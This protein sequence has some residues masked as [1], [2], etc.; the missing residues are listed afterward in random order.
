[1]LAPCWP[2]LLRGK[3]TLTH[4]IPA[5]IYLGSQCSALHQNSPFNNRISVTIPSSSEYRNMSGND[6]G[7]RFGILVARMLKDTT[8]VWKAMMKRLSLIVPGFFMMAIACT[9]FAQGQDSPEAQLFVAASRG[10]L[11]KVRALLASGVDPNALDS[12]GQTLLMSAVLGG[13]LN[14][15][16]Q[17]AGVVRELVARGVD[18]NGRD[19]SGETALI[20]CALQGSRPEFVSLLLDLKANVNQTN[21]DGSTALMFAS[22]VGSQYHVAI[23][24][25]LIARGADV[26]ARNS[27][28]QTALVGAAAAGS[29]AAVRTLIGAHADVKAADQRGTNALMD[30]AYKGRAGLFEALLKAGIDPNARN[31]FGQTA[32]MESALYGNSDGLRVLLAHKANPNAV[33]SNGSTALTMAV[34]QGQVEA[35]RML[36]GGGADVDAKTTDGSTA[37]LLAALNCDRAVIKVL[38]ESGANPNAARNGYT[39]LMSLGKDDAEVARMLLDHG[40]NVNAKS[41]NGSTALGQSR[42]KHFANVVEVLRQFGATE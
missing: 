4:V 3:L 14:E 27:V 11:A 29:E 25:I 19:A 20:E 33:A 16:S 13:P 1:M 23:M 41:D 35:I 9:L 38:L 39:A 6:A 32:L 22:G 12:R 7:F 8:H 40:A 36:L 18:V 15:N 31:N 10:D 24:K 5:T 17:N 26:N 2:H 28:G 21:T 34:S 30:A 37:L 42:Y